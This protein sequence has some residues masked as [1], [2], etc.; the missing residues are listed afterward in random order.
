MQRPVQRGRPNERF[1]QHTLRR[2]GAWGCC[3]L[4]VHTGYRMLLWACKTN[5][6]EFCGAPPCEW[7]PRS[8]A[9]H[10]MVP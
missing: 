3:L 8:A 10:L 2:W 9:M 7:L 1:L 6:N 4:L 5:P